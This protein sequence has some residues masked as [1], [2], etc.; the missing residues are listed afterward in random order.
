MLLILFMIIFL[1]CH[2]ISLEGRILGDLQVVQTKYDSH[3]VLS[4]AGFSL[5]EIEE[6]TRRSLKGGSDRVA[7]GGPDPQHHS[8]PPTN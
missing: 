8:L 6:Y 3:F 1:F 2:F 4:K 5:T 7:P